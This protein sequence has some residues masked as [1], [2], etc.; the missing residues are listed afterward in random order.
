M[1]TAFPTLLCSPTLLTDKPSYNHTSIMF[2]KPNYIIPL[3]KSCSTIREFEPIH[4]HL[5]TTNF[6]SDPVS[7]SHVLLFLI[8][9]GNIRYVHRVFNQ[10]QESEFIVW[11]T[12]IE[13]HLKDG[14]LGDVFLTYYHMVNQSVPLDISTFHFLIH[15]CSRNLEFKR[16][17]EVHGRVWKSGL[18]K[19]KSLNNNFMS[20]YSKCGKLDQVCQLFEKMTKRDIISWN[21]MISCYVQIGMPEEA[22][23]LFEEMQVGG[24]TP[25][26][27]TMVSLVSACSKLKSMEMG[28]KLHLYI[29][30]NDFKISGNLLN[31]LV[32]MYIQCG[33][34]DK[35]H[36]LVFR[37]KCNN[38]VVLWTALVGGYVKFKKMAEARF[39]FDHMKERNLI[40]WMTMISGYYQ[41]G[42]HS[43]C[44]KLF[45][46]MRVE[47]NLK[48][49][50]VLMV[51]ALS[52]C[53]HM[54]DSKLGRSIHCLVVKYGMII[55]GFL[56]NTLLH[57][58]AKSRRLDEAELIFEKLP[59]K[60]I[61]SWNSMLNGFCRSGA[62]DKAKYFFNMIPDKDL[63]SW[64]TLI[65]YY[66][67]SR[68]FAELF[69]LFCEMQSSDIKP[70][71]ITLISVLSSCASVGALNN[72]IWVHTYIKKNFI[73]LDNILGT[74]LIDMYGKCGS[75][76]N[77]NELFSE[78][79]EKNIFV[80]T[81]MIAA[82]AME[83]QT[84]KAIDLYME[85][86][87]KGIKPDDVTFIALL[88]ACNHGG[89]VTEGFMYFNKM[90]NFYNIIPKIQHYGCM[91]D[92]LGR[93]GHLNKAVKL[94]ELMPIKPDISIWSSL[95][96]ACGS[97]HNVEL[98]EYAFQQLINLDSFNVAA[99]VLLSNIYAKVGRW[100]DVSETRKK[101]NELG[102]EKQLGCSIIEQNGIIHEFTAGD[103]S[104]PLS[105][106]IYGL[107]HEMK[108]RL[109]R[110]ELQESVH[111]SER[112]A[113]A[114]GLISSSAKT[115][116]RVVNNLR[117]CED[118][119]SAMKVISQAYNREIVI[120]DN[121]RFHR[122]EDGNCSCKDYW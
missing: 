34:M 53:A 70:D 3:L 78:M 29:E 109:Q 2:P 6:I 40:S 74:A 90:N 121:Y 86:E 67:R 38:D 95:M 83:G 63:V 22:L 92:L 46:Q 102:V 105:A 116:I 50:E 97:H 75:I 61:A 26:E 71:K 112:L 96:R 69:K 107:L 62:M 72:G 66:V 35:A 114:Y 7:A 43:K 77:A 36:E 76:E 19:N 58:Y 4:A 59:N 25:D 85:M 5:I 119:H 18:G 14:F 31:C 101:L 37:R 28:E 80:W 91:V 100:N 104:N 11:N 24:V 13:N 99:Y 23:N 120:R 48:P 94:I 20:L 73:E 30:K 9:T 57:L 82:H 56:G 60:N 98:A 65:N 41:R 16:G 106:N 51:T 64:N 15:A 42:Y 115:R 93:A 88:S 17:C 47:E 33:R 89:L 68:R 49:D 103:F 117:M 8:S 52:A 113:A 81:A 87:T 10:T 1:A 122:F 79:T 55:H 110:P 45:I 27:I 111:H 54:E 21:T 84:R 12:L 108:A 32:Y 118:C 44:L 39:V